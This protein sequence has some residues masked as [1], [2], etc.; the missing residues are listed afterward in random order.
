[1]RA[2]SVALV[3]AL[4]VAGRAQ[5]LPK[6]VD[7]VVQAGATDPHIV[8]WSPSKKWL[9][10]AGR[11]HQVVIWDAQM[12]KVLTS[13][14]VP[15]GEIT[16]VVF[17]PIGIEQILVSTR[18][19]GYL[20]DVAKNEV[21]AKF[22]AVQ[23]VVPPVEGAPE[24]RPWSNEFYCFGPG[25]NIYA[26]RGEG[27]DET[28]VLHLLDPKTGADVRR[29]VSVGSSH[30]PLR[31]LTASADGARVYCLFNGFLRFQDSRGSWRDAT[32]A[33][34]GERSTLAVSSDEKQAS[35]HIE[36]TGGASGTTHIVDLPSARTIGSFACFDAR[37]APGGKVL[38]VGNKGDVGRFVDVKLDA[39]QWEVGSPGVEVAAGAISADGTTLAAAFAGG[40]VTL[41]TT[42]GNAG[43]RDFEGSSNLN[44]LI[45]V[46]ADAS[47]LLLQH[48]DGR[49]KLWQ[50]KE[51]HVLSSKAL[52]FDRVALH[53][54]NGTLLAY[55]LDKEPG[56]VHLYDTVAD[57]E[58]R[59]LF[60]KAGAGAYRCLTFSPDGSLI[61]ATA[62]D[63]TGTVWK[64]STGE[65]SRHF[66]IGN[67]KTYSG[68]TVAV[69]FPDQHIAINPSNTMLFQSG[70]YQLHLLGISLGRGGGAYLEDPSTEEAGFPNMMFVDNQRM[71]W[72]T[73]SEIALVKA[74]NN[75]APIRSVKSS[76]LGAVEEFT[77][78]SL[79]A[80]PDK[81]T[82]AVGTSGGQI[83]LWDT[84]T[85]A[86]RKILAHDD[87]ITAV[88]FSGDGKTIISTGFDG[89]LKAWES[90]SGNLVASMV[91]SGESDFLT[92]LPNGLYACSRNA[93]KSVVFRSGLE[94]IPFEDLDPYLNRPDIVFSKL[95]GAD[96]LIQ[97]YRDI[98]QARGKLLKLDVNRTLEIDKLPTVRINPV[99]AVTGERTMTIEAPAAT[100]S[101]DA[102]LSKVH[103]YI[104]DIPQFPASGRDVVPGEPDKERKQSVQAS[105]VRLPIDLVPGMNKIQV[106]VEDTKGRKSFRS[107]ATVY[108][109]SKPVRGKLFLLAV[110][111][112]KNVTRPLTGPTFDVD[113][114]VKAFEGSG[115]FSSVATLKIKDDELA[116][117]DQDKYR[118]T[119]AGATVDDTVILYFSGHG[120]VDGGQY[121]FAGPTTPL[122]A[123]H[124]N[125]LSLASIESLFEGSKAR[126]RLVILDTCESGDSVMASIEGG[127]GSSGGKGGKGGKGKT[128]KGVGD[129]IPEP[130]SLVEHQY[131]LFQSTF[132]DLERGTGALILSAARGDQRAEDG[133][134]GSVFTNELVAALADPATDRNK[135]GTITVSELNDAVRARVLQ[136]GEQGTST[137][138]PSMRRAV[139][140]VDFPVAVLHRDR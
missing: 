119:L 89:R 107:T 96:R 66:G 74:G 92:T 80:S 29:P 38:M 140:E 47:K 113:N 59:K 55:T 69:D 83:L 54:V 111:V 138:Q 81:K 84:S 20:V 98:V 8:A 35:V 78:E 86:T 75:L 99:R 42:E 93:F 30:V 3:L 25:G 127:G 121:Y 88:K 87:P 116:N 12:G 13:L 123:A 117:F 128:G 132:N 125:G 41:C 18:A 27:Q 60:G 112:G 100:G 7:V 28:G 102:P 90:Q 85:G 109:T 61:A 22:E 26:L 1:M 114:I 131:N 82:F 32:F 115:Q 56:V 33:Q 72:V 136:L 134:T 71:V 44:K 11:S 94:L 95:G 124:T 2:W 14:Y 52:A 57:R 63:S 45:G 19:G 70:H 4:A 137:Q 77:K 36:G 104:N 120:V 118:A 23:P 62:A 53:P 101:L 133:K 17:R 58:V 48:S 65:V 139:F 67:R 130:S 49:I 110:G 6:G 5:G 122:D 34:A 50:W 126:R 43:R 135:D 16:Q 79:A 40:R 37:V 10:V 108:C 24:Y 9:A 68:S 39:A 106:R 15:G 31:G 21:K 64:S 97:D 105:T 91:T 73:E 129:I 103:L 76:T 46:S 51:G